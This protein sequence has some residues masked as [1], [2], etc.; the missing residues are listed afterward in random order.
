MPNNNIYDYSRENK[1]DISWYL[2]KKWNAVA[3]KVQMEN[4]SN[5]T[6]CRPLSLTG[7]GGGGWGQRRDWCHCQWPCVA[8]TAP[9]HTSCDGL[10][11]RHRNNGACCMWQSLSGSDTLAGPWLSVTALSSASDWWWSN[12]THPSVSPP[13]LAFSIIIGAKPGLGCWTSTRPSPSL[14][15]RSCDRYIVQPNLLPPRQESVNFCF[16]L[17]LFRLEKKAR[18][19]QIEDT[20]NRGADLFDLALNAMNLHGIKF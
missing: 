6:E 16:T 9:N 17:C 19:L 12:P 20:S 13:L 5:T 3:W 18:K 10:A 4:L 7:R 8:L 15:F 1:Q 11:I 2:Q 14:S